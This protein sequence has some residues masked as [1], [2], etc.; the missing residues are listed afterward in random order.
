[1]HANS[2]VD[3]WANGGPKPGGGDWYW[4]P[5]GTTASGVGVPGGQ[6]QFADINADRRED[7]LDVDPRTGATRAWTNAG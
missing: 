6:I 3:L 7:Y 4:A 2:A 5:Q 1:M